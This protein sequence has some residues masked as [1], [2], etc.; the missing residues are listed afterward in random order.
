[1]CI[2]TASRRASRRKQFQI[3]NDLGLMLVATLCVIVPG[4]TFPLCVT[5][6]EMTGTWSGRLCV[7][8]VIDEHDTMREVVGVEILESHDYEVDA[9]GLSSHD[10]EADENVF[11]AFSTHRTPL[12]VSSDRCLVLAHGYPDLGRTLTISGVME[13]SGAPRLPHGGRRAIRLSVAARVIDDGETN[14]L[15]TDNPEL[16]ILI[17]DDHDDGRGK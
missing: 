1:M 13:Y 17:D 2:V 3:C 14:L 9:P 12:L 11:W 16:I 10:R 7:V 5:T 6:P 15:Y 4:C 8:E